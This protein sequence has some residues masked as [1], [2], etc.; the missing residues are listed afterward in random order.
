MQLACKTCLKIL[1]NVKT[2]IKPSQLRTACTKLLQWAS[3]SMQYTFSM[4]NQDSRFRL[5]K[6]KLQNMVSAAIIDFEKLAAKLSGQSKTKTWSS[7]HLH[8]KFSKPRFTSNLSC[9]FHSNAKLEYYIKRSQNQL[10]YSA[11]QINSS[12]CIKYCFPT[13]AVED[14]ASVNSV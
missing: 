2:Q 8:T 14:T 7:L 1:S 11:I 12:Q 5:N 4:Y 10:C 13:F 6:V 3:S 9:N